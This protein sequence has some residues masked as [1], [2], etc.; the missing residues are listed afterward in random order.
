M[1]GVGQWLGVSFRE[2]AGA[3]S[4]CVCPSGRRRCVYVGVVGVGETLP[5][6]TV[7]VPTQAGSLGGGRVGLDAQVINSSD[8]IER[9]NLGSAELPVTQ[10]AQPVDLVVGLSGLGPLRQ[11]QSGSV[12]AVVSNAGSDPSSG[13]VTVQLSAPSLT[14][15]VA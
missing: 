3:G 5:D 6:L 2:A 1:V 14:G 11:G 12:T 7:S 10:L 4:V 8:A 13:P 9:D 15:A